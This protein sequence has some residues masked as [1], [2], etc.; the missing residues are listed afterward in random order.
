MLN[1]IEKA[2]EI[3][4]SRLGTTRFNDTKASFLGNNQFPIDM[5]MRLLNHTLSTTSVSDG[6]TKYTIRL[7]LQEISLRHFEGTG[8]KM[9]MNLVLDIYLSNVKDWVDQK[10]FQQAVKKVVAPHP[11]ILVEK[12]PKTLAMIAK[13]KDL[14]TSS[15]E[16]NFASAPT[17][18]VLSSKPILSSSFS[19]PE[20]GA[21]IFSSPSVSRPTELTSRS[22]PTSPVVLP[23]KALTTS[24][25]LSTSASLSTST[26]ASSDP[27]MDDHSSTSPLSSPKVKLLKSSNPGS[28]FA[29]WSKA[30]HETENNNETKKQFDGPI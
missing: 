14:S 25:D 8:N 28:K 30:K 15:S 13:Q 12:Y 21:S 1:R 26:D 5:A 24:T 20:L 9:F 19:S 2:M 16:F 6:M 11:K 10:I 4:Q 18:P 3:L 23:R 7:I 29:L 17:S 22:L 27:F